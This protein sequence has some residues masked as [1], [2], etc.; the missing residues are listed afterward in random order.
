MSN[1]WI[2]LLVIVAVAALVMAF[3]YYQ[4]QKLQKKQEEAQENLQAQSQRV[5]M[6]VIDKKRMPIKDANLPAAVM[7]NIPKR[8]RRAKVPIVKA[9]IG[10]QILTMIADEEVYD[11]IPLK[12]SVKADISGIYITGINNYRNAPVPEPEKKGFFGKI[13]QKAS[14]G[15]K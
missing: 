1:F 10:P 14:A 6:L 5:T 13:R 9:K 12:A 7:D 8:Y 3:L 4:G 15:M 2:V 11:R